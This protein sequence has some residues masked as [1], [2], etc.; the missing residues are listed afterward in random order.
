MSVPFSE[1]LPDILVAV[2]GCPDVLAKRPIVLGAR[3]LYSQSQ[4]WRTD[5]T[6]PTVDGT[7]VYAL[8][9]DDG[10]TAGV[11]EVFVDGKEIAAVTPI[12][13]REEYDDWR[14]A[15]GKPLYYFLTPTKDIQL[16]PTPDAVSTVVVGVFARPTINATALPDDAHQHHDALVQAALSR[17]FAVPGKAFTSPDA[18]MAYAGLAAGAAETARSAV[19]RGNTKLS[20]RTYGRY[21]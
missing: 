13:L 16:V 15:V 4:A 17:I 3:D 12:D 8:P 5:V 7:S 18:A 21:F 19:Q 11:V 20:G 10:E 14:S 1:F 2:D 9:V 6:F